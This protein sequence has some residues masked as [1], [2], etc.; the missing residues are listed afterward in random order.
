[1]L[2]DESNTH[3]LQEIVNA[4]LYT[5]QWYSG[6][7]ERFGQGKGLGL[8][9]PPEKYGTICREPPPSDMPQNRAREGH[10]FHPLTYPWVVSVWPY[11]P[12]IVGSRA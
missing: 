12:D 10:P 6:S 3:T 7:T 2:L 9:E 5:V 1:M 4:S 8:H 11:G